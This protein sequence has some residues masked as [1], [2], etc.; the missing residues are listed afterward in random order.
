MSFLVCSID[1][2][3]STIFTIPTGWASVE[4]TQMK[5]DNELLDDIGL[6]GAS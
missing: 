2:K 5:L 3:Y 4:L 1:Q 6:M